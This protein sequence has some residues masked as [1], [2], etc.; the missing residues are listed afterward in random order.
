MQQG[1]DMAVL[2]WWQLPRQPSHGHRREKLYDDRENNM[3]GSVGISGTG[4]RL[5]SLVVTVAESLREQI[6]GGS[7][8]PGT[9]LPSEAQLCR[10][11]SVSRTVV[12]EAVAALRAD[13]LVVSRQ[14]A[15]VFVLKQEPPPELPFQDIQYDRISSMIE[16]LEI[17]T[18]VEVEAASLAARRRSPQQEETIV[19][20]LRALRAEREAGQST[21]AADFDLHLAIAAAT[22][23]PRFGEFLT[24][25]G[26]GMIPRV[27]LRTEGSGP[28]SGKYF[29]Q[30]DREHQ[31]I[32]NA[33]LE[34]DREAARLAMQE[35]LEGS[36]ARYRA[37]L[38]AHSRSE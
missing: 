30:I 9:R 6:V 12:R 24:L 16:V 35:H 10:D 37:L 31:T 14:G 19:E 34:G 2:L 29:A 13:G 18:A 8:E 7:M 15:G 26:N 38:R 28:V 21:S 1:V 11:H 32:V 25:L 17:R 3:Q 22:S 27:A 20:A 36:Q 33:I 5:G 23:N 4:A